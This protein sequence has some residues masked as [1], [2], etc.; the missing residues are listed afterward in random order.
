[1]GGT[2]TPICENF[3][4]NEKRINNAAPVDFPHTLGGVGRPLPHQCTSGA[5]ALTG[6]RPVSRFG[7]AVF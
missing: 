3:E 4:E 6:L 5:R 7:G 2:P 1:M